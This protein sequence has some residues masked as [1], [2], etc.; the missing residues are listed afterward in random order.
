M[1]V[2]FLESNTFS[3]ATNS[4]LQG[5]TQDAEQNWLHFDWP[6]SETVVGQA[7]SPGSDAPTGPDGPT[8]TTEHNAPS[9]LVW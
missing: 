6:N 3:L 5:E 2:T 4:S 7:P 1:D 9:G 8:E